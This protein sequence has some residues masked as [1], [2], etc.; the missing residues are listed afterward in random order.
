MTIPLF[1]K[2]LSYKSSVIVFIV[3]LLV[4]STYYNYPKYLFYHPQSIH[5]WRQSD[6]ASTA[7][8]YSEH[9][10]HF[11][12]P[13]IHNLLSDGETTGYAVGEL[14]VIYYLAGAMYKVFG[15]HEFILRGINLLIVFIGLFYF[16]KLAYFISGDSFWSVVLPLLLFT[17]PLLVYYSNNYLPEAPS[18]GLNIIGWYFFFKF[19]KKPATLNL[20]L[21]VIFFAFAAMIKVTSGMSLIVLIIL[22]IIEG[23]GFVL[24]SRPFRLYKLPV[25]SVFI[26][27][28]GIGLVVCWYAF[29]IHYNAIHNSGYFRTGIL[30]FW[31]IS[32]TD[33]DKTF[34]QMS[35]IW[36][37]FI[38]NDSVYFI[39]GIIF[40]LV[41]INFREKMLLLI[42]SL[43]IAGSLLF[44]MLWFG[45]LQ[46]HDYYFVPLLI[47]TF[48]LF[49]SWVI[50]GSKYYP[51][52]FSSYFIK[53]ATLI[54]LCI[55]VNYAKNK[56]YSRYNDTPSMDIKKE[57]VGIE[58][59]A[60]ELGIH[61][62][63]KVICSY[64]F[65]P[66]HM[67]YLVNRQGW[68]DFNNL[69]GDSL[70]VVN[71][72]K[73]GAK[74]LILYEQKPEEYTYLHSFV[75]RRLGQKG[76]VLFFSLKSIEQLN[77]EY[78]RLNE[79]SDKN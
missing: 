35:R 75:E 70:K 10:M 37:F 4:V 8:L 34:T 17:S 73:N 72:I 52:I 44:L 9:G 54:L 22:W 62:S 6:C 36:K 51:K 25:K 58:S 78:A 32:P 50:I 60:E 3:S 42:N 24:L 14:P 28:T 77:A 7:L 48:L 66:N 16:F 59:Y 21:S 64:D 71:Q 31:Q 65:S 5:F 11:F 30:G 18:L 13:E 41:L 47:L 56:V 61:K 29:A 33:I 76:K 55:N 46:H 27:I 45:L 12:K 15:H 79:N 63:D 40:I 67:L 2:N 19:Y 57:M 1:Q 43:L 74:Y 20:M 23:A 49:I 26:I 53:A 69:Q 39:M 68:T 38:F